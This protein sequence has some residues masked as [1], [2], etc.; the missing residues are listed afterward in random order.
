MP[1]PAL[2]TLQGVL[3]RASQIVHNKTVQW[4]T[5]FQSALQQIDAAA[6]VPPKKIEE[7]V[8]II[9]ITNPDRL[10]GSWSFSIDDGPE[11]TI[12]GDAKNVRRT[13]GA[14][15]SVLTVVD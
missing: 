7:A 14:I 5:E 1:K 11:E 12:E 8:A 6:K 10:T 9:K 2:T 15:H 4:K 13:P 3:A